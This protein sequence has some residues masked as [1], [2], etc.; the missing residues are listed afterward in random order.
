MPFIALEVA[1]MDLAALLC[2]DN[3]LAPF[4]KLDLVQDVACGLDAIHDV[5]LFHGDLK[6]ANV[7][8][9]VKNQHWVAKL[10]DF[11]GAAN[12]RKDSF[13]EGGGTLGWRAPEVRELY[14]SGKPLD[15][16]VLDR[17]DNYSFG[18]L[19]W[20]VFF[21]EEADSPNDE[22]ETNVVEVAVADLR[23]HTQHM[24]AQLSD[25]LEHAF[26]SLLKTNPCLREKKL[27][28]LLDDRIQQRNDR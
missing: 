19:L 18:L 6:P 21:R 12:L 17:A 3:A 15:L 9:F 2:G 14:E 7:L 13:W 22:R 27:E 1:E 16:S 23:G 11:G 5:G 4:E 24:P 26:T 28:V 8:I 25:T 10:A 20:S